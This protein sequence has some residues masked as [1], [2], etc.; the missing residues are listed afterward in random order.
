[1]I[2]SANAN[3]SDVQT[4]EITAPLPAGPQTLRL[5]FSASG[6]ILSTIEF[7]KN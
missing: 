3:G 6:T 5:R 4:V 7:A 2:G 1:V